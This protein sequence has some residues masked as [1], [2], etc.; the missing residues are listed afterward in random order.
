MVT[1]EQFDVVLRRLALVENALEDYMR[2]VVFPVLPSELQHTMN[3]VAQH[4]DTHL[5]GMYDAHK[6]ENSEAEEKEGGQ[7]PPGGGIILPREA[8]D[9]T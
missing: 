3:S 4:W 1:Q 5:R 6:E 8:P 7:V 9:G 2:E